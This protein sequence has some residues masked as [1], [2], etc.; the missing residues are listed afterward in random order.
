MCS[1]LILIH[2]VMFSLSFEVLALFELDKQQLSYPALLL[3][4]FSA[5][6]NVVLPFQNAVSAQ[7]CIGIIFQP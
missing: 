6:K 5:F 2:L 1:E 4:H 3:K 7:G